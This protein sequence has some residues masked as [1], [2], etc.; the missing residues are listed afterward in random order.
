MNDSQY[1][2][3]GSEVDVR[4]SQEYFL[5]Y[6]RG[7]KN[8]LDIGC[9]RGVFMEMLKENGADVTGI[10]NSDEAIKCCTNKGLTVRQGEALQ[11]LETNQQKFDGIFCAHVIEHLDYKQ[12]LELIKKCYASLNQNGKLVIMTPNMAS[13]R[14]SSRIFWLDPTHVRPYPDLLLEKMLNS[15]N[16]Q[17]EKIGSTERTDSLM[18]YCRRFFECV[19]NMQRVGTILYAV[20]IKK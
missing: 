17:V 2:F 15:N 14:I 11:F 8:V 1:D 19:L 13:Q 10:D 12:A 3:G 18:D 6:F 9:G 5:Q 4:K 20:A 16:F 7:C